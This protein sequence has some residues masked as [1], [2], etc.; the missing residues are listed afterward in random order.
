MRS[1][2]QF[3][4]RGRL[5]ALMAIFCASLISFGLVAY[6]TLA[7]VKVGGP[8]YREIVRGKDL[9]ADVLPPPLYI[10][11]SYQEMLRMAGETDRGRLDAL[12]KRAREDEVEFS[13]RKAYW[14][15]VLPPGPIHDS[16]VG[17]VTRPAIEFYEVLNRL[18][19]P[20]LLRDQREVAFDLARGI[21]TEKY[22]Q[23]RGA[24][25][26]LTRAVRAELATVE[27]KVAVSTRR[28]VGIMMGVGLFALLVGGFCAFLIARSVIAPLR[29]TATA[30]K[31]VASGDLTVSVS[32]PMRDEIGQMALALGQT[33]A[34]MRSVLGAERIDWKEV[35]KQRAEVGRIKQLVENAP[36]NIM[37]ADRDLTLKYMN[38]AARTSFRSLEQYLPIKVDDMIGRSLDAFIKDVGHYRRSLSEGKSPQQSRIKIGSE[39]LDLMACAI[40][41]EAGQ[42]VGAMVSWEVITVRL[43]AEQQVQE[44]QARELKQAEQRRETDQAEARR[45]EQ[46]ASVREAEVR[47]RAEQ[48]QRAAAELRS[49]VDQILTVVEQAS[50]GDLTGQVSV[51]GDDAIGRLGEGLSGFFQ[52]LRGSIGNISRNAETVG[53]ASTQVS[54]VGKQLGSVAAETATQA[55]VVSSAA[56]E[57]SRNVQ[58]AASGT[59][60]MTSSIREIARSASNAA[61]VAGQAVKVAERT[62]GTVGKLGESSAE[63]GKVIK[64]ITSIAQQTNLLALNATIEAARAGEAGKGFAVVA[65]EVKELAKETARATEEIGRKIEAIQVDTSDAVGAIR[66][67]SEIIGQINAIQT[68]IAGAVEEQTATTNE[69]SRNVSE[70]ARGAQEIA[71][72]IQGVARA[73]RD[74]T[75]GASQ[76]Q[77]ASTDLAR[78]ATDL[79]QL[80]SQFRIHENGSTSHPSRRTE[81]RRGVGV[82]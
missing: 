7:T 43:A 2:Q 15:S 77:E 80:V 22:E 47:S 73:A 68:T 58:T 49:K 36:L 75:E 14:D 30:L 56:D 33:L 18:Y 82:P 45:R 27:Q 78:A 64:V 26:W 19:V 52:N 39:T 59:E 31:A 66:E 1:F 35:G 48:E 72:N 23:Q 41:D 20:A 37:Y 60:E 65:N 79:Q 71:A 16:L 67:I 8:Y 38:P 44:A 62:N 4:V 61:R 63:I 42:Y 69:I 9:I 46:E 70:A 6:G 12:I 24:A 57:V 51:R 13:A 34:E 74:T 54:K 17:S 40:R 29:E 25:D 32:T 21:L 50:V 3:G 5:V 28:R 10:T 11:E 55:S 53:A 76:S 81:V